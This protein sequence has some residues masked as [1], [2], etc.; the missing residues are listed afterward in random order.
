MANAKQDDAQRRSHGTGKVG[1]HRMA[2]FDGVEQRVASGRSAHGH[3]Q[4]AVS[5]RIV[6]GAATTTIA[7]GRLA[8]RLAL[9]S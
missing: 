1:G 4:R 2:P 7:S 5:P 6:T 9:E 3:L 8:T